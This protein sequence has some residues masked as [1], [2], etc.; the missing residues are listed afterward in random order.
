[1]TAPTKFFTA[2]HTE[3]ILKANFGTRAI[4]AGQHPDPIT[5]AVIPPLSLST[6]FKQ[7]GAGD[8]NGF[9]YSRSGNPSRQAFETAVAALEGGK[10]GLAFSSGSA[11]TAT[12][13]SSLPAGSHIV[14]VNDVYGGTYRYFTK[15]AAVL[16][17]QV[18]FVDLK[19]ASN[20][21]SVIRP[22]TKMIWIETPTN[23]TLRLVDIKAVAEI[24]R[25]HNIKLVVD[26]TFMSPY[27][28]NPLQ[29]GADIVVHS[30][31]K[32]I[33]GHSDVVMGVAVTSDEQIYEKLAFLQN[34]IGAVPSAFDCFLANRGL[35]TLHL[36]MR[37][38]AISAQAIAEAL[39]ASPR[40]E[41]VIYPG[42]I[43]HPQHE[44]AKRQQKGFGGMISFRIKGDLQTANAFLRNVKFFTLAESLGGVESLCE[45]PAT[46]T[47]GSVSA[48]DRA[49]LG[50]TENL[51]RLSVGIEDTEDLVADV[52]AALEASVKL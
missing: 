19:D 16:N 7:H 51:I 24:A 18:S 21:E 20:V 10:Y 12:I 40:V 32:Y 43:S 41:N 5:G 8:H 31:T 22:N 15:V 3:D 46:M 48:E 42:L 35:K 26:N 33:N 47:H 45:L 23:P 4:H 17:A 49:V 2:D 13:V 37:Q 27:F 44:L 14:S 28:Q 52:L 9:D 34:S 25:K 6:T 1:M 38:H 39:E 30:V 29:L 50:I 11:T 36:R